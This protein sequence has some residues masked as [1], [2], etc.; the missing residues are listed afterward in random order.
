VEQL[1]TVAVV[2]ALFLAGLFLWLQR[3]G[4]LARIAPALVPA[5]MEEAVRLLEHTAQGVIA[6]LEVRIAEARGLLEEWDQ[7]L[8]TPAGTRQPPKRNGKGA[9]REPAAKA[10]AAPSVSQQVDRSSGQKVDSSSDAAARFMQA[11]QE[12]ERAQQAPSRLSSGN[13]SRS[14]NGVKPRP[15][16]ARA[17]GRRPS[18]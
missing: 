9:R 8:S 6:E 12:F 16:A 11:L 1:I 15:A 10:V 7:R 14:S 17:N 5:R 4:V 18:R 2:Q 13:G 3:K